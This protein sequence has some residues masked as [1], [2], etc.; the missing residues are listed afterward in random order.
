MSE[1][2][3][4]KSEASER[5]VIGYITEVIT[6]YG[7][8]KKELHGVEIVGGSGDKPR[9]CYKTSW[10][11]YNFHEVHNVKIDFKGHIVTPVRG[12]KFITM[13]KTSM[14]SILFMSEGNNV[15]YY[16][17]MNDMELKK[18]NYDLFLEYYTDNRTYKPEDELTIKFL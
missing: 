7:T 2:K 17:N 14:E 15:V 5:I 6:I 9:L 16:I 18:V 1:V 12:S 11:I 13:T 4:Y 8:T 3:L 10:Q